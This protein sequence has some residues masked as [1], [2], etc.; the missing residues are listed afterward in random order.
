MKRHCATLSSCWTSPHTKT[1]GLGRVTKWR[2]R[3]RGCTNLSYLH[4]FILHMQ[5]WNPHQ[6]HSDTLLFPNPIFYYGLCRPTS[7]RLPRPL[8]GLQT[9]TDDQHQLRAR[10]NFHRSERCS[11]PTVRFP[12][13]FPAIQI[14]SH[15]PTRA[16][17]CDDLAAKRYRQRLDSHFHHPSPNKLAKISTYLPHRFAA[18]SSKNLPLP[19]PLAF[20][21]QRV[22]AASPLLSKLRFWLPYL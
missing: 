1:W 17:D 16:F 22:R 5:H 21:L 3:N 14:W 13:S 9:S 20:A 12:T 2:M 7:Q 4:R 6:L 10:T 19:A 8:R 18:C 15:L 11:L